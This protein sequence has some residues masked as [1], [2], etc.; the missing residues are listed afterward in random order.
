MAIKLLEIRKPHEGEVEDSYSEVLIGVDSS[1]SKWIIKEGTEDLFAYAIA[2]KYFSNIVPETRRLDIDGVQFSC[3]K[4]VDAPTANRVGDSLLS[5]VRNYTTIFDIVDLICLDIVLKNSDR[6]S[7]NWLLSNSGHIYAID[8]SLGSDYISLTL[9]LRPAWRTLL[10]D[11]PDYSFMFFNA[12][13]IKLSL[14]ISMT[15]Q[16]DL[17]P[18]VTAIQSLY[19]ELSSRYRRVGI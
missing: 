1:S 12:L 3:Q 9:A 2:K 11:D 15:G 18:Y 19:D 10:V 7:N 8:N 5:R 6:H 17:Y 4:F 16:M 14:Y 13:S